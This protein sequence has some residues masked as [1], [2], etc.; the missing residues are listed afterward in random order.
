MH[1]RDAMLTIASVVLAVL[2]AA[3][4]P[5]SQLERV[6]LSVVLT[7]T[8]IFVLLS[9]KVENRYERLYA[10]ELSAFLIVFWLTDI[11]VKRPHWSQHLFHH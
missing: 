3:F 9:Q 1:H 5:L 10:L 2:I 7:A 4:V 8:L 6:G 11:I